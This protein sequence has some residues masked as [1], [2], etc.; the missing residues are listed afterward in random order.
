MLTL[1]HWRIFFLLL[2]VVLL[3]NRVGS[4][5]CGTVY[6]GVR[7]GFELDYQNDHHS[8]SFNF[9]SFEDSTDKQIE[10]RFAII[11]DML[12]TADIFES[13]SGAPVT[14]RC[15]PNVGINATPDVVLWQ[16]VRETSSPYIVTQSGLELRSG[17]TYYILLQV[18]GGT[19]KRTETLYTNTDGVFVRGNVT[20]Y[21][22]PDDD[23]D[24]GFAAW[25]IGLITAGCALFCL[26]LLLLLLIVIAKGK[27]EDKY[28]TTV[29]RNDNVEKT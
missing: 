19:R 22:R 23:D 1:S 12:A 15:R 29:H 25:K 2:E 16:T 27:G 7:P 28:T 21:H 6:D 4:L 9:D 17:H 13:G 18:K 5:H 20:Y 26:L 14:L 8:L 10:Y 24:H 3:F 11:S